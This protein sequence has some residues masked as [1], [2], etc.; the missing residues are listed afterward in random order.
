MCI[1]SSRI[2]IDRCIAIVFVMYIYHSVGGL[3]VRHR[4]CVLL[5]I[6]SFDVLLMLPVVLEV[7]LLV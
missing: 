6:V 4:S 7:L 5:Y 2:V 1:N 3:A